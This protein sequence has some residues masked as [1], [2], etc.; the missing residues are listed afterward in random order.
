MMKSIRKIL[1]RKMRR[2]IMRRV[3]LRHRKENESLNFSWL[4]PVL[5]E[6]RT[7]MG[8]GISPRAVFGDIETPNPERIITVDFGQDE[9]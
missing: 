8:R 9:K 2:R 6:P 4:A 5:T 7:T 1:T 3:W